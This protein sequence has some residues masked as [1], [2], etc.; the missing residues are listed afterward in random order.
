MVKAA[1]ITDTP[2]PNT[3][4]KFGVEVKDAQVPE[5]RADQSVV[6]IQGAAFNHR[7]VWILK[8]HYPEEI[9]PGTVL[10]A[11]AVGILQKK[12]TATSEEGQRVI[13]NPGVNWD[14]NSRGP[15]G[16][17]RILG[18]LPS[19]G[20]LA[21]TINI[22]SKE[23][24]PCPEHL[25]T[26]EA[27]A[28]PLV[29]LTAYRALF[30]KSEVKKGDYVLVTGIG[31][32]VALTA[33]QFAV[34]IGAHVYVSSSNPEKIEFAKTLG[35]EGGVNYKDPNAIDDLKKQLNGHRI[36]AVIDGSGGALF[37]RLAEVMERGGIIAQY[38]STGSP[39][40]VLFNVAYWHHNVELKGTTMGSRRE[41]EEMLGFVAKYKIKPVVSVAY[42]GL[43]QEN[44]ES[45]ISLLANH[46]QMGKVV[47]EI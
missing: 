25:S 38:G 37:D 34:A 17:F 23:V 11:D 9:T 30:T 3:P 6:K 46:Q 41:F 35:A 32:G 29:G 45:A 42:K 1:V 20:T 21:E 24:F 8:K 27:A 13:I 36:D 47:I 5:P 14:S 22:D 16:D 18:L 28:L 39:Q 7:D 43:T 4:F 2:K 10:G 12:G 15:E 31:G 40:G 19:P 44:V 33:L 26:A